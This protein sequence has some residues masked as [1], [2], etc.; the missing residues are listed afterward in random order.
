M[1]PTSFQNMYRT[2][3]AASIYNYICIYHDI[4]INCKFFLINIS[5]QEDHTVMKS[6]RRQ[7]FNKVRVFIINL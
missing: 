7:F 1:Q 6:K 5:P 3:S 2:V 4:F